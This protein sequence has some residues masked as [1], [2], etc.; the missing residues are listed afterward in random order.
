MDRGTWQAMVHKGH[1]GS[2]TTERLTLSL[3]TFRGHL[4]CAHEIDLS[5][6]SWQQLISFFL[7]QLSAV[8]SI[9]SLLVLFPVTVL[10]IY[11]LVL[12]ASSC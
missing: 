11:T 1:K 7:L 10:S 3:F 8:M 4:T 9:T 6:A 12:L 2:D 5:S